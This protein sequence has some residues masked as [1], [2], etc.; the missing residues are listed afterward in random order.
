MSTTHKRH[1]AKTTVTVGYRGPV[2]PYWRQNPQA[3]GGVCIVETCACGARRE[4]NSTGGDRRETT[5]WQQR[6]DD[7]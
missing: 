4:T 2:G 3:H 1:K 7:H 5:G 6:E